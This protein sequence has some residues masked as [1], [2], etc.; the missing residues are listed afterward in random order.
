MHVVSWSPFPLP[1]QT[2]L[3]FPGRSKFCEPKFALEARQ[4]VAAGVGCGEVPVEEAPGHFAQEPRLA[5]L[6]RQ[7]FHA[8]N[9]VHL[10]P[11]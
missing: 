6:A 9:K 11:R 1:A 10:A 8:K 2:R 4:R 5:Q 3:H 7:L